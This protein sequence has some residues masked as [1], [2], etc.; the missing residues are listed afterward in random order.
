MEIHYII[1]LYFYMRLIFIQENI[2]NKIK[3]NE[4]VACVGALNFIP[5]DTDMPQDVSHLLWEFTSSFTQMLSLLNYSHLDG[6]PEDDFRPFIES[7]KTH[8][9]EGKSPVLTF[10]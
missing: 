9:S 5:N 7:T 8:F 4:S 2:K 10:L 6:D 3:T 1:F